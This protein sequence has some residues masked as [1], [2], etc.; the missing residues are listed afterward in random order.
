MSTGMDDT[1]LNA[2]RSFWS[3]YQSHVDTGTVLLVEYSAKEI[4]KAHANSIFA[5][6]LRQAKGLRPELLG[7]TE[8]NLELLRG[9][10]PDATGAAPRPLSRI[11]KV[12]NKIV[13][14][15]LYLTCLLTRNIVR[16]HNKGIKIGDIVYDTYL[17]Q[18]SVATISTFDYRLLLRIHSC[19][20]T[21]S[22]ARSYVQAK[23]YRAIMISHMVGERSAV[24]M[25][26]ALACGVEVFMRASNHKVTFQHFR[27]PA[28]IWYQHRPRP[29]D[30]LKVMSFYGEVLDKVFL[31][32]Y[33]I[34][35]QGMLGADS[36]YAF[37]PALS[38]YASRE[39]FNGTFGLANDKKSVF[40]MLHA[41]NDHPHSHFNGMIFKDYYDWFRQTLEYAKCDTSVNW[42]FK[43][44]PSIRFYRTHDVAY[45]E[46]FRG[47][48]EH[49]VYIDENRQFNS[50]CVSSCADLIVTCT[51]SAGYHYPA[52]N[53]I[54]SI[55]AGD[56]FYANLGFA[57][58]PKTRREYFHMLGNSTTF[59]RLSPEHIRLARATYLFIHTISSTP[60]LACPD[61]EERSET[62]ESRALFWRNVANLYEEKP[63][64]IH[65]Q[66]KEIVEQVADPNFERLFNF[67]SR[68]SSVP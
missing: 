65:A 49:I 51:G 68:P 31:E 48:G 26:T 5:V 37:N 34:Q 67:P 63:E 41:M 54:P 50:A 12:L 4:L 6:V 45:H 20:T 28:D 52:E 36:A 57:K 60:L 11:R 27:Q 23:R 42:I 21:C 25:R 39:D 2:T 18:Y 55:I 62:E 30:V 58:E 33:R 14:V 3:P 16:L 35:Q 66:I 15:G 8:E 29:D 56:T 13:S 46:L 40:V 19:V 32:L 38:Q 43:Q 53:G 61:Y 7:A 9:Y 17:K 59:A 24:F 1:V 64:A 44:H 47:T 10:I 22:I